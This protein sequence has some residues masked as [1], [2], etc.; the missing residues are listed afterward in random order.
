[1]RDHSMPEQ[2]GYT[3]F[4]TDGQNHR[5]LLRATTDAAQRHPYV[6]VEA[7]NLALGGTVVS[8]WLTLEQAADLEAALCALRE[9]H[10]TNHTGSTLTVLPGSPWTTFEVVR[11]AS[12][13]EESAAVRVVVLTG[14][15]HELRKAFTTVAEHARSA[16][17]ANT[18]PTML[19][20]GLDDVLFGD[21]DKTTM[22]LSDDQRRPYWLELEPERTAAL[23]DALAG[24][25]G[26]R[27]VLRVLTPGEHDRAWN[28]IEGA[29]GEPGA[30]TGTILSAVLGALEIEAPAIGGTTDTATAT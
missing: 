23:R 10:V 4:Y 19:R 11:Q 20:W 8:M 28:A 29:T 6:W 9:F 18:D 5:L 14:R 30:D 12:G 1:M 26:N 25:P 21:D 27:P 3:Y 13:D 22:L 7:E 17:P 2:P 16:E 24:I 15:L